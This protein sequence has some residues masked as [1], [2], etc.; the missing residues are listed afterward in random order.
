MD[1]RN[2]YMIYWVLFATNLP[3]DIM[4]VNQLKKFCEKIFDGI[5]LGNAALECQYY[6]YNNRSIYL[7]IYF[8][9]LSNPN[10][11][12]RWCKKWTLWQDISL[13]HPQCVG[14][15][16]EKIVQLL[17]FVN[18]L[19]NIVGSKQRILR[20]EKNLCKENSSQR[21]GCKESKEK[22]C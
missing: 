2:L 17:D 3:T 6:L 15:L 21:K 1:Q 18:L 8:P 7:L 19:V 4:E 11:M 9:M 20:K 14:W 13:R 12:L 10:Q 16:F 5:Y 22:Y